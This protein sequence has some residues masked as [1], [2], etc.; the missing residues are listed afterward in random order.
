MLPPRAPRDATLPS[1]TRSLAPRGATLSAM[2]SARAPRDATPSAM[3]PARAPRD[4]T[5]AARPPRRFAPVVLAPLAALA[6]T[7][8]SCASYPERVRVSVV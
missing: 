8:C 6:L 1:V 2:P 3:P 7:L 5:L 4:T